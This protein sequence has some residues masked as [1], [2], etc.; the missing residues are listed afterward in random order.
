MAPKRT[1]SVHQSESFTATLAAAKRAGFDTTWKPD[2]SGDRQ[3]RCDLTGKTSTWPAWNPW[4][5]RPTPFL[6]KLK[7]VVFGVVLVPLRLV[8]M[9]LTMILL[10]LWL[11]LAIIGADTSKPMASWRRTI[12]RGP[13]KAASRTLMLLTG[14]VWVSETRIDIPGRNPP[15]ASMIVAN[16]TGYMEILYTGAKFGCCFVAKSTLRKMFIM[17]TI[18][19]CSQAIF[20]DR[21]SGKSHAGSQIIERAKNPTKWPPLALYPEGTTTN[22]KQLIK[23][24]TGAFIAGAPVIPLVVKYS[25]MMFDPAFTCYS[26]GLHMLQML[27]QPINFMHVIQLPT[28]VPS[29]AEK[30]DPRLYANNVRELISIIGQLPMYDLEWAE[31][32]QFEPANKREKSIAQFRK[33][34]EAQAASGAKNASTGPTRRR[35]KAKK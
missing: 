19:K 20:V 9:L 31:K 21:A 34:K 28:Y 33:A 15:P 23:F 25:S 7:S 1:Q 10:W 32:L 17:G 24:H 16:H 35:V 8:L 6:G 12:M 2:R 26:T 14:F 5:R 13:I 4:T 27:A 11:E 30:A 29:E 18:M 3:V 22:G